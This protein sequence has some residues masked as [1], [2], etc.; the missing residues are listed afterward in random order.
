MSQT[1]AIAGALILAYIVF[2]TVRGELTGYLQDLG[3]VSGETPPASPNYNTQST[4]QSQSSGSSSGSSSGVGGGGSTSGGPANQSGSTVPGTGSQTNNPGGSTV[5]PTTPYGQAPGTLP[6]SANSTITYP[7]FGIDPGNIGE[8]PELPG[9]TP[10]SAPPVYAPINQGG[11]VTIQNPGGLAPV[12]LP[13]QNPPDNQYPP[14]GSAGGPID[15][16]D[17]GDFG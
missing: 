13:N 12:Q 8:L 3:I 10:V 9:L 15:P 7:N 6:G 4:T 11:G 5:G 1:S 17:T 14:D 16:G 2:I